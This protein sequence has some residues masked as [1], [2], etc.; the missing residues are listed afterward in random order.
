MNIDPADKQITGIDRYI[1][2]TTSKSLAVAM[3]GVPATVFGFFLLRMGDLAPTSKEYIELQF[4]LTAAS[5]SMSLI[6]LVLILN[7]AV[8]IYQA[9]HSKI[10]HYIYSA[11]E[12]NFKWLKQNATKRHY[13]FILFVFFA[14]IITGI[15]YKNL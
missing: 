9:K 11:P 1:P 6:A 2:T 14:G 8:I 13:A 15:V 12:M 10:N 7:L 3:I 4:A 5:L